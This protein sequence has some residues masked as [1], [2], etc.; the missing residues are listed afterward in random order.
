MLLGTLNASLLRN[1]LTVKGI[2]RAGKRKLRSRE[3]A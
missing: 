1:T 2:S 3:N